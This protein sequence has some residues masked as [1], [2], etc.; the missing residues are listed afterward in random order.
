MSSYIRHHT[1]AILISPSQRHHILNC[2]ELF[3]HYVATSKRKG[4][5]ARP[6]FFT[7]RLTTWRSSGKI[8]KAHLRQN[9]NL[10]YISRSSSTKATPTRSNKSHNHLPAPLTVPFKV[11]KKLA[12]LRRKLKLEKTRCSTIAEFSTK[13]I[14]DVSATTTKRAEHA[15]ALKTKAD[16][17]KNELSQVQAELSVLKRDYAILR[18]EVEKA[19]RD[20][21]AE[22]RRVEVNES[23]E[24][25]VEELEGEL[26]AG[27]MRNE[28]LER[29]LRDEKAKRNDDKLVLERP[30]WSR[31][32]ADEVENKKNGGKGYT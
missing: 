24:Q 31:G 1:L 11:D 30:A 10:T 18:E 23:H 16:R 32:K 22:K 28:M 13:A 27:K 3:Y 25:R 9:V 4:R 12:H 20:L 2:L 19:K 7:N 15:S 17:L 29:V 6:L 14:Q 5:Q 21:R 26:E 8:P